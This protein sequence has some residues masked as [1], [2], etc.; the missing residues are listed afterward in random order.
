MAGRKKTDEERIRDRNTMRK[1]S[2]DVLPLLEENISDAL[3]N[4][5]KDW[6]WLNEKTGTTPTQIDRMFTGLS[7]INLGVL[8]RI[9]DALG[10]SMAELFSAQKNTKQNTK[11][12]S[13]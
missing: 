2:Q 1:V 13:K 3:S 10:M 9:S 8:Y 7:N 4:K 11:Q 5:K 6:V 12:N